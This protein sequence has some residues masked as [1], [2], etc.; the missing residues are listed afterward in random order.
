MY[1]RIFVVLFDDNNINM[2]SKKLSEYIAEAR[3]RG[4]TDDLIRQESL[5]S[6]WNT[7]EITDALSLTVSLPKKKSRII[8]TTTLIIIGVVVLLVAVRALSGSNGGAKPYTGKVSIT[9]VQ[10]FDPKLNGK[11]IVTDN[12]GKWYVWGQGSSWDTSYYRIQDTTAISLKFIHDKF[13][14]P[15]PPFWGN[16]SN[17]ADIAKKFPNSPGAYFMRLRTAGYPSFILAP[18]GNQYLITAGNDP[19]WSLAYRLIGDQFIPFFDAPNVA[20]NFSSDGVGNAYITIANASTGGTAVYRLNG[21][22]ITE[23]KGLE[24]GY[25]Y[26]FALNGPDHSYAVLTD[27]PGPDYDHPH[28]FANSHVFQIIG[29]RAVVIS[30][31]DGYNRGVSLSLDDKG[32]V[33]ATG[34]SSTKLPDSSDRSQMNPKPDVNDYYKI[35]GTVV[36]K[37]AMIPTPEPQKNYGGETH[38]G[39]GTASTFEDDLGNVYQMVIQIGEPLWKCQL[40]K[41]EGQQR[42]LVIDNLNDVGCADVY[43]NKKGEWVVVNKGDI[44]GGSKTRVYVLDGRAAYYV[45]D[46]EN[47]RHL[48]LSY[49]NSGD[50]WY[51]LTQNDKGGTSIDTDTSM[52]KISFNNQK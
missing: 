9:E 7:D 49:D 4:M 34:Q 13:D 47:M 30:Q 41:V 17:S 2:S 43:T 36:T 32:N 21:D 22:L 23:I 26:S 16:S 45:K 12:A 39:S 50:F 11:N 29:D 14:P 51:G 25:D 18:N 6:G 15:N 1:A 46:F 28:R 3:R 31:L 10:G 8:I 33:Y 40:Y 5:K 20:L 24:N 37:I 44:Y 42:Y 52:Y 38:G 35:S 27:G 19:S 48:T